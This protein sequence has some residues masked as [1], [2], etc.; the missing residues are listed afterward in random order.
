[1]KFL[2]LC[3]GTLAPGCE[4]GAEA[5]FHFLGECFRAGGLGKVQSL[6]ERLHGTVI[7]QVQDLE[8]PF[9]ELVHGLGPVTLEWFQI[10]RRVGAR[11]VPVPDQRIEEISLH[12]EKV[13]LDLD[14]SARRL[15]N[16]FK[17]LVKHPPSS[18]LCLVHCFLVFH[19]SASANPYRLVELRYVIPCRRTKIKSNLFAAFAINSELNGLK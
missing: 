1:M 19:I 13:P 4:G 3:F 14:G 18:L 9:E 12:L 15:S 7:L 2:K 10:R 5:L 6:L 11:L 16:K 8:P 17:S